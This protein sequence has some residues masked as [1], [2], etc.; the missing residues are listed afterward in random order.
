VGV[1]VGLAVGLHVKVG[2][3]VLVGENVGVW[4]GVLVGVPQPVMVKVTALESMAPEI[5]WVVCREAVLTTGLQL[6]PT[7]AHQL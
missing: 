4:V 2:V 7:V 6:P 1:W 5:I 3:G